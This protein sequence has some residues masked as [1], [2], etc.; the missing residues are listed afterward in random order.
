MSSTPGRTFPQDPRDQLTAAINAVFSSWNSDR[1][2]LYRR[3]ERIPN[4]LGTAVNVVAMVF[5]NTGPDS[6]TGV[7]FTRDPATGARGVY[8]D[9]LQ[10]AQGE[11]VVAGIR[12][13]VP[14]AELEQIDKRSYD[15]LLRIM[16]LLEGHYRDLCDIEFTIERGTLWM[17]QTRVGKRTAAAAF[18][19]ATQLID[20]GLIDDDEALRRVSGG[21]LV[22]LMFPQFDTSGR[23]MRARPGHVRVAR[24]GRGQGG[25]RLLHGGEVEPVGGEGDPGAPGD[26]PGRPERHDRRAG[27][28]DQSRREDQP[29]RGRRPRDGQDL[30]LRGRGARRR[31]QA[32]PDDRPGRHRGRTRA[33]SSPSTA[34]PGWSTR[35]RCR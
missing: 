25:L 12:N 15:E 14:L 2:V 20:E 8:G 35:A 34:R 7:C 3:Q 5:G 13:T 32:A 17:L 22:Q 4:E 1:A 26:Q 19:I 33:T 28:P 16:A 6:G 21:Q 27:H 18:R 30:R 23:H 29:C 9:Y 31:H 11:D 10:N 24:R